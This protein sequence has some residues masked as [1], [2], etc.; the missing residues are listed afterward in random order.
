MD[1][2]ILLCSC[3]IYLNL[4]LF[5]EDI[6]EQ[7]S[8][9]TLILTKYILCK[10]IYTVVGLYEFFNE[11]CRVTQITLLRKSTCFVTLFVYDIMLHTNA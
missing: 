9:I 5:S 3:E 10:Y 8:S 11:E 1:N 7:E 2:Q 4:L 6:D